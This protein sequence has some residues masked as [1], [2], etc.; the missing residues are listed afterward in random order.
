ME[1]LSQYLHLLPLQFIQLHL[2]AHPESDGCQEALSMLVH[3]DT[4]LGT[5]LPGQI[6]CHSKLYADLTSFGVCE[7]L[8]TALPISVSTSTAKRVC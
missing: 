6:P 5:D 1:I 7:A 4:Q 3:L 2:S 8:P